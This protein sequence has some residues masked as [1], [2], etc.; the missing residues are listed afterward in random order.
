MFPGNARAPPM[1]QTARA[2]RNVV[3]ARE[4]A[5]AKFVSGPSAMRVR[6]S[7]GW[8]VRR[9]R[10][11]SMAGRGEGVKAWEELGVGI[12]WVEVAAVVVM[13]SLVG[14]VGGEGWKRWDQVSVGVKWGCWWLGG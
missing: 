14:G 1:M 3:G 7:G 6:V 4:A 13:G 11:W 5:R 12:E 2:R 8:V 10:I 9:E